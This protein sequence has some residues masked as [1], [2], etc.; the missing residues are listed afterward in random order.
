MKSLSSLI[1]HFKFILANL[2][3]GL[4]KLKVKKNSFNL[5]KNIVINHF[6][7]KNHSNKDV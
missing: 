7:Y 4:I 2:V 5:N 3:V 6:K 1:N